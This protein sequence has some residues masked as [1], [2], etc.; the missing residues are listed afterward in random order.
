MP[1]PEGGFYFENGG[2]IGLKIRDRVR[3]YKL[4][5]VIEL[6]PV[7]VNEICYLV[8]LAT[9]EIVAS[10]VNYAKSIGIRD[11]ARPHLRRD[12]F[13]FYYHFMRVFEK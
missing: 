6:T 9:D 4:G 1:L 11:L 2:N 12:P 13:D 10:T 5:E 7:D 3:E 8:M